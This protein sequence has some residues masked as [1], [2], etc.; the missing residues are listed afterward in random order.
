MTFLTCARL[1][2]SY[3]RLSLVHPSFVSIHL[4]VEITNAV[5]RPNGDKS[6][7]DA[8]LMVVR[9]DQMVATEHNAAETAGRERLLQ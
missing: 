2:V 7:L 3:P 6:Y 1:H 4:L 9:F 8:I 5:L